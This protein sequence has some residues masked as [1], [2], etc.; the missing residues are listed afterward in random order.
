MSDTLQ[1]SPRDIQSQ[2][3]L[4]AYQ[5]A[6]LIV[7]FAGI[8]WFFYFASLGNWPLAYAEMAMVGLGGL[9]WLL[10]KNHQINAALIVSEIAF[11]IFIAGFCLV[12]DI[13]T[14]NHPRT[15]H[16]FLPAIALLAYFKYLREKSAFQL[17]IIAASLLSFIY[18]AS[19]KTAF[20]FAQGVSDDIRHLG[21][22]I[23][24]S[25]AT[26]M[27]CGGVYAIQR[28]S[29]GQTEVSR[30]LGSAVRKN[31]LELYFQP[32]LD[33]S[34]RIIGAEAL[35]R[36]KHPKRGY[37]S[38]GEFIPL[39]EE[40]GLMPL[41]GG[42]VLKEACRTLAGWQEDPALDGLTLAVN[43]S[44]NQFNIDGFEQ[45]VLEAVGLFDVD[46]SR[47]KLELTESVIISG[48]EPVVAKMN[49]LRASGIE[50]ALDDFGTGYSSLSY[51]R[52]LPVSQLKIDR[53]FVQESMESPGGASLI[54]NIVRM[55]LE[56]DLTV[57]AEGIETAAQHLFLL[58]CGCH[59]FQGYYF[60]RPVPEKDFK[61]HVVTWSETAPVSAPSPGLKSVVRA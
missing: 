33:N 50:F 2:R 1:T 7:V 38:P 29:T 46:P 35:L 4:F 28:E 5:G 59:E 53:S 23:N 19:T 47:L 11:L 10:I 36:W 6:S 31:Q 20:P 43:V 56:L 45:S 26:A 44:A 27:I 24:A 21:I 52:Q 34:R 8:G 32:Q 3:L 60:G 30:A 57:L 41:I 17:F 37:I 58:E 15:S 22:W 13:P 54:R 12:F 40:N 55:G 42:W 48:V 25:M 18:F 49:V 51:L 16:L 9:G 14:D 61:A 39:A